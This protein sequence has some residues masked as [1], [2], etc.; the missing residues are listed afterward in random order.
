MFFVTM[1]VIGYWVFNLRYTDARRLKLK[2]GYQIADNFLCIINLNSFQNYKTINKDFTIP[3]LSVIIQNCIFKKLQRP[4]WI[5]EQYSYDLYLLFCVYYFTLRDLIDSLLARP[6]ICAWLLWLA[7]KIYW[8]IFHL[9]SCI[10]LIIDSTKYMLRITRW[11]IILM[12]NFLSALW[13]ILSQT[14]DLLRNCKG[15]W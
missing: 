5:L 2:I 11:A 12:R 7:K 14:I 13:I 3:N 15:S 8:F 9:W 4:L 1:Q 6:Q 10:Y